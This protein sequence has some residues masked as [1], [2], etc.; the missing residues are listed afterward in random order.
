LNIRAEVLTC[1]V[2]DVAMSPLFE[3]FKD[4]DSFKNNAA[5]TF[6]EQ[7]LV[8]EFTVPNL[9]QYS[10]NLRSIPACREILEYVIDRYDELNN[11]KV[12]N[13]LNV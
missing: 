12:S 10:D 7:V 5:K 6:G 11:L 2:V 8:K 4:L 1:M 13:N 3:G 9:E